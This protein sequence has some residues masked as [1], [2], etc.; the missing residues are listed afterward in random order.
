MVL[1]LIAS[2]LFRSKES[3]EVSKQCLCHE[4]LLTWFHIRSLKYQM[5]H[6]FCK[7]W[8]KHASKSRPYGLCLLNLIW[9]E[10]ITTYGHW[11]VKFKSTN[12]IFF[13]LSLYL[14]LLDYWKNWTKQ[15]EPYGIGLLYGIPLHFYIKWLTALALTLLKFWS[16]EKG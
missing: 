9:I 10:I 5:L 14:Q 1:L 13:S 2:N 15:P 6:D 3:Q 7:V 12:Y 4:L 11:N 8:S 16:M